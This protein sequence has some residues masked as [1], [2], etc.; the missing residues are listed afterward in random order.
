MLLLSS[1]CS[2]EDYFFLAAAF[3]AA[4]FF[5]AAAFFA[6]AFFFATFAPPLRET[7]ECSDRSANR[8]LNGTCHS[9]PES[10]R[11]INLDGSR[12]ETFV[13]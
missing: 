1:H 2:G 10:I 13:R 7:I 9:E 4:A 8:A 3:L 5:G 12:V 6:A 11:P